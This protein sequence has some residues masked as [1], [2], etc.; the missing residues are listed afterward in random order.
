MA[1]FLLAA[2]MALA[3]F[4]Q[5]WGAPFST[6]YKPVPKAGECAAAEFDLCD[7]KKASPVPTPV[8]SPPV[9][10]PRRRSPVAPVIVTVPAPTNEC[11][12]NEMDLCNYKKIPLECSGGELDLCDYKISVTSKPSTVPS[13][14]NECA[15][16]EMDLCDYKTSSVPTPVPSPVATPTNACA[17]NEMDLCDYKTS[18]VPT[19]V[20]SPVA[21]VAD[22]TVEVAQEEQPADAAKDQ[23]SMLWMACSVAATL[24]LKAI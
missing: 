12:A 3:A 17:A 8:A 7:Y 14:T 16:N 23:N 13:P 19:P 2:V 18:S 15:A 21:K 5:G 4:Q 22:S 11:A 10:S 1:R 9:A 20:P 6:D 24:L